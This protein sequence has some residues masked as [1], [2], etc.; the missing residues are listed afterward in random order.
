ME[1]RDNIRKKRLCVLFIMVNIYPLIL[2][3][4]DNT[5][6][7]GF[8]IQD[9]IGWEVLGYAKTKIFFVA[10]LVLYAVLIFVSD[11]RHKIY[12]SF[13]KI[14]SLLLVIF[15]VVYPLINRYTIFGDKIEGVFTRNYFIALCIVCVTTGIVLV[16]EIVSVFKIRHRI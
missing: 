2:K 7:A 6:P 15:S 3:W 5:L 9:A 13:G 12:F 4:W 1:K 16:R 10:G 11:I 14:V 8:G